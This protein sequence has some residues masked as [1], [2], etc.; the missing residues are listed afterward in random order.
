MRA[1]MEEKIDIKGQGL[2][3]TYVQHYQAAKHY[4]DNANNVHDATAIFLFTSLLLESYINHLGEHLLKQWNRNTEKSLSLAQKLEVVHERLHLNFNRESR[5]DKPLFDLIKD[6]NRITH[7]SSVPQTIEARTPDP[8][9]VPDHIKK[10]LPEGVA[11]LI[12]SFDDWSQAVIKKHQPSLSLARRNF[13]H[14]VQLIEKL[15]KIAVHDLILGSTLPDD[16]E[17]PFTNIAE[18]V[19]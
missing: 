18:F 9:T 11:P 10:Q 14:V 17:G 5:Q 6:R 19:Y 13:K 8:N 7:S 1:G 2:Y 15:D 16:Y 3:K 12:I 4:L